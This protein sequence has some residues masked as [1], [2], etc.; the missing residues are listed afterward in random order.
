MGPPGE[1][2]GMQQGARTPGASTAWGRPAAVHGQ[3]GFWK[4]PR[5]RP[6]GTPARGCPHH[7]LRCSAAEAAGMRCG[8]SGWLERPFP[9]VSPQTEVLRRATQRPRG[10]PAA[11]LGAVGGVPGRPARP[12]GARGAERGRLLP[13]GVRPQPAS[14]SGRAAQPAWPRGSWGEGSSRGARHAPASVRPQRRSQKRV[15]HG[16]GRPGPQ[17]RVGRGGRRRRAGEA[18]RGAFEGSREQKL[19]LS[20]LLR[21]RAQWVSALPGGRGTPPGR[22]ELPAREQCAGAGLL[23]APRKCPRRRGD[24]GTGKFP[25][26]RKAG[27]V[28]RRWPPARAGAGREVRA[29]SG[30][31]EVGAG[32]EQPAGGGAAAARTGSE[33]SGCFQL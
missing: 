22:R 3:R 16:S 25:P 10:G 31:L 4:E 17:P 23:Q 9:V 15:R 5:R 2:R 14:S 29:V 28:R 11:E 20:W 7:L 6:V 19:S 8:R 33:P 12:S 1:K 24:G 18:Q 32:L 21:V 30:E 13:P 27:L 26:V